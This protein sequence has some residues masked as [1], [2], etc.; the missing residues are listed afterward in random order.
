MD[1]PL[2]V[3]I[4]HEPLFHLYGGI[5]VYTKNLL[6]AARDSDCVHYLA[7][8]ASGRRDR[9]NLLC[10]RWHTITGSALSQIFLPGRI[11]AKFPRLARFLA[12]PPL[13]NIDLAHAVNYQPPQWWNRKIPLVVTICDLAFVRQPKKSWARTAQLGKALPQ[14]LKRA[15]AVLAISEFT[16]AEIE[17]L[18]QI[19]RERIFV[20]PLSAQEFPKENSRS[21]ATQ[22][23][24]ERPYF[25]AVSQINPR[26]NYETLLAAFAE[27]RKVHPEACLVIVGN[28]GWDTESIV[29]K[30]KAAAPAVIWREGCSSAE[31]ATLYRHARAFVM[32]SWYEGFG[33]PC[34]EAMSLGCPVIYATGSALDELVGAA[35]IGVAP[36]DL[37]KMSASMTQLWTDDIACEQLRLAGK[38]KAAEYSLARTLAATLDAYRFALEQ[39]R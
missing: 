27:M 1:K 28:L 23:L 36:S 34:L 38:K 5:G 7:G 24:P 37:H 6:A 20:S 33:I 18:Y 15:S 4:D 12:S 19:P 2:S 21:V 13:K 31:V 35:G 25:L 8:Y 11:A 16:A 22:I 30:I 26:K 17:D 14:I 3:L 10:E 39:P 32:P 9:Q 29:E